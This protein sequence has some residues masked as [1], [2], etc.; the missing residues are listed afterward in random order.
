[1]QTWS[2]P[3]RDNCVFI[4]LPLTEVGLFKYWTALLCS[5]L[6]IR[7]VADDCMYAYIVV[8]VS[9][10]CVGAISFVGGKPLASHIVMERCLFAK[11]R[12]T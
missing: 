2:R 11:S 7:L 8:V 5:E 6:Q 9:F 4:S 10:T 12:Q 3:F 1:M